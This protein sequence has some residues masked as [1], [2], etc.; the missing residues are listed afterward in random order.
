MGKFPL[1]DLL[2]LSTT[3]GTIA[4]SIDPQPADSSD[5]L[6]PARVVI[7]SQ[8]GSVSVSFSSPRAASMPEFER[9]IEL[10]ELNKKGNLDAMEAYSE[11]TRAK[12]YGS[13][14]NESLPSRPYE[15]DIETTSGSVTG[16]YMFSTA[17]SI[18]TGSG[19]ISAQLVP[20][21]S[22][23]DA[24]I[25]GAT[26]VS[27]TTSTIT[28]STVLHLTEPYFTHN[29]RNPTDSDKL[30]PGV[31]EGHQYSPA[32]AATSSHTSTGSGSLHISYPQSWAGRV[33]ASS[34]GHGGIRVG[35]NGVELQNPGSKEWVA[36][37]KKPEIEPDDRVWWGCKGN[38]NTSVKAEGSGSIQFWVGR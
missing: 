5:P 3:S 17:A 26:N 14:A 28:G 19:S 30:P 24:S 15:V 38:M 8:S 37:H 32:T 23:S 34:S 4:V 7:R 6:K 20:V 35:G 2:S 36:G 29:I 22:H 31:H 25:S 16:R 21:V 10:D 1:Y 33:L 11:K 27:L 18:R 12:N 9:Q 13:D